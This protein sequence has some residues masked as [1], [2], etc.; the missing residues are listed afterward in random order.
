MYVI[1]NPVDES[2]GVLINGSWDGL[3]GMAV[4]KVICPVNCTYGLMDD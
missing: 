2:Y 1:V 4:R 3:V